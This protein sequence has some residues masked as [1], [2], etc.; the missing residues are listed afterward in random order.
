MYDNIQ[1]DKNSPKANKVGAGLKNNEFSAELKTVCDRIEAISVKMKSQDSGSDWQGVHEIAERLERFM[2]D[3]KQS[4]G[5]K[6]SEPNS[7]N[8][9]DK[10]AGSE[11]ENRQ[12]S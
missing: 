12:L 5:S 10:K 8:A 1:T 9:Y 7:F 6:D 4:V 2:G 11:K 3:S